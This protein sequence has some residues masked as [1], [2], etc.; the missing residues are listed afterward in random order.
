MI[1]VLLQKANY[2]VR[3]ADLS[4]SLNFFVDKLKSRS[5]IGSLRIDYYASLVKEVVLKVVLD[6]VLSYSLVRRG[7][8]HEIF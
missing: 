7:L 5:E 6:V 2:E 3:F 1:V 8:L 4:A